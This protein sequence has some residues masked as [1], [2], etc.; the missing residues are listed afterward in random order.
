MM[1]NKKKKKSLSWEEFT[2]LG[3]PENA[4]EF[5]D[6]SD[7]EEKYDPSQDRVRIHLEKKGRRGKEV[8]IVR[9]INGDEEFIKELSK[10]I[11]RSCGVGG[12]VKDGEIIVQGNQRRKILEILVEKGYKNIKLAGG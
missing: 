11:K 2:K 7:E 10:E 4:P 1:E 5:E 6:D 12:S 8:S 3:N 9:G